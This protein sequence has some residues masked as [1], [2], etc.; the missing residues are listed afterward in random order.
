MEMLKQL[1]DQGLM[2][3]SQT[4]SLNRTLI[5]ECCFFGNLEMLQYLFVL[6]GPKALQAQDKF[7]TSSSHFAARNGHLSILKYLHEMNCLSFNKEIKFQTTP[8]ELCVAMKHFEC[9]DFLLP[10]APQSVLDSTLLLCAQEGNLVFSKKLVSQG[11]DLETRLLDIGATP[12]DRFF[13]FRFFRKTVSFPS[14]DRAAFNGHLE[15][16]KFLI[17]S[18]CLV[19]QVRPEDGTTCLYIAS[20][21]GQAEIVSLLIEHGA[22]VNKGEDIS[23]YSLI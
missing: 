5:H 21:Q 3:S 7:H 19:N 15:L 16:S 22:L 14:S 2:T 17:Q 10:L 13:F 9:A 18:G 4:Y 12:L 6:W 8:L 11:A 23:Q 1:I 20:Q